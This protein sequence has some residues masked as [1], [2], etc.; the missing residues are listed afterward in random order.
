[1]VLVDGVFEASIWLLMW[2]ALR[3]GRR[4]VAPFRLLVWLHFDLQLLSLTVSFHV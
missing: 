4:L 3:A 1:M 2:H